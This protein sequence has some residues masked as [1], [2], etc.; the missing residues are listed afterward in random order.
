[1]S[2]TA[3]PIPFNIGAMSVTLRR[4]IT[5]VLNKSDARMIEGSPSSWLGVVFWLRRVSEHREAVPR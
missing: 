3:R 4:D 1:M 5:G 2:A